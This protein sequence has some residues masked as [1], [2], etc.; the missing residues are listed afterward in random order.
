VCG[1]N[2]PDSTWISYKEMRIWHYLVHSSRAIVAMRVPILAMTRP[3]I[4]CIH[5]AYGFVEVSLCINE[6]TEHGLRFRTL[7]QRL[8]KG[9]QRRR[10]R[11]RLPLLEFLY[12]SRRRIS[13]LLRHISSEKGH[14][15]ESRKINVRHAYEWYNVDCRGLS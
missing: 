11:T 14:R 3:C 12:L 15:K 10:R 7:G 4:M 5:P 9:K 6:K 1:Q 8:G 2:H 13:L